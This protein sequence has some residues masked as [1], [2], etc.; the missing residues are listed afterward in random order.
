MTILA[1]PQPKSPALATP[2]PADRLAA[3]V[4]PVR[5]RLVSHALYGRITAPDQLRRFMEMHVWAVWDFQSLLKAMQQKLTC[6]TVPWLP[7]ADPEARRLANEIVLDE[8]SDLLPDGSSASHFELYLDSMERAGADTRAIHRAIDLLREGAPLEQALAASG[9]PP[10]SIEFVQQSFAV[11]ES[12]SAHR[13]VA[14]FTFGREDVIPD[15]FRHLVS[16]LA[17]SD[18]AAWGRF[19]FYLERHI[20]HDDEKHAPLCRRIVARMCGN[21]AT[22]W[23]EATETARGCLEAR[24]ALWDAIA[25]AV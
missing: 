12:D 25:A 22:K 19:R 5:E 6:T 23:R 18:P 11:I 15:M 7:S 2:T 4:A 24:I 9:G 16:R 20:E 21:D 10:A 3:A 8:E 1:P 13:I 17:E 14:A